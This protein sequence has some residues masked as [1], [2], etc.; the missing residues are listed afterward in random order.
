MATAKHFKW[1]LTLV[2]IVESTLL[3]CAV[4][5]EAIGADAPIQHEDAQERNPSRVAQLRQR[6]NSEHSIYSL[7]YLEEDERLRYYNDTERSLGTNSLFVVGG[8]D[9][10]LS[11]YPYM[12]MLKSYEER[13]NQKPRQKAVCGGVLIRPDLVL[14]AGHCVKNDLILRDSLRIELF[15]GYS[16]QGRDSYTHKYTARAGAVSLHDQLSLVNGLPKNDLAIIKLD[17]CSSNPYI[18]LNTDQDLDTNN[19]SSLRVI[20]YGTTSFNMNQLSSTLQEADLTLDKQCSPWN[21]TFGLDT[22]S[23]VCT[24]AD[25]GKGSCR[26]DSG[27]PIIRAGDSNSDDR[28]VGIVSFGHGCADSSDYPSVH[29]RVRASKKWIKTMTDESYCPAHRQLSRQEPETASSVLSA[30]KTS[31]SVSGTTL[32]ASLDDG[33]KFLRHVA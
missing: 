27:G 23:M 14:T 24:A 19:G 25:K 31:D 22:T 1:V 17:S 29:T 12:V 13:T 11:R 21:E 5:G 8:E 10:T 16:N 30:S 26:G 28:L 6:G 3:Y 15:L 20:G 4:D 33:K 7:Q 18:E 9:A 2:L 32:L